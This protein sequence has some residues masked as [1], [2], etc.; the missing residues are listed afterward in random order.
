MNNGSSKLQA[1]KQIT[2]EV[3]IPS[4]NKLFSMLMSNFYQDTPDPPPRTN[5]TVEEPEEQQQTMCVN[6]MNYNY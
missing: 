3:E 2:E 6:F 1:P 4:E 5:G